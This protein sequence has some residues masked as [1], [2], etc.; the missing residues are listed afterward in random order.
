MEDCSFFS[1]IDTPGV[2]D[3]VSALFNGHPHLI[4]GFNTFLPPGYRIE[5][6]TRDDPNSIRVTTPMGTTVSQMSAIGTQLNGGSNG[7]PA[8]SIEPSR[9]D[10]AENAYRARNINWQQTTQTDNAS[11]ETFSPG[12]RPGTFGV[13]ANDRTGQEYQYGSRENENAVHD[14]ATMAQER[15]VSQLQNAVNAASNGIQSRQQV[16]Q[17]SP[18][19]GVATTLGQVAGLNNASAGILP[20]NQLGIEK[21]GPVE[22]NHAI[23]YVNK[24]K[25]RKESISLSIAKT[26]SRTDLLLNQRSTS[27]SLR[28]CKHINASLNLS[29][30]SMLKS[31]NS[32]ALHPIF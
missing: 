24:I 7:V 8:E 29:K 25:V 32:L 26:A 1:R 16:M 3:R 17:V 12:S 22:F 19:G 10:I 21:R 13:H 23:S 2:I 27:N 4:Q 9:N 20:G 5:C 6:G 30:T 18:S 11:E 28:Y 31:H 14:S 15:G